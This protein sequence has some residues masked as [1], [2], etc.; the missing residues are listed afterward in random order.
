MS[1]IKTKDGAHIFYKDWGE[2]Q[3]VVFSHGWPLN[4][5]A[6]DEQ[7]VFLAQIVPIHI[8]AMRSSELVKNAT[9]KVYQGAPHAL[10]ATHQE[11]LNT[12]LLAFI[13]A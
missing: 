10:M 3:P 11:Q 4:A 8:T 2:G 5:D 7:L 13:K 12:D 6:W 1:T 9:L